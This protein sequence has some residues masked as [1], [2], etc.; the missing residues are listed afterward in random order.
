MSKP[1]QLSLSRVSRRPRVT[2][3]ATTGVANK[4]PTRFSFRST[5]KQQKSSNEKEQQIYD[6]LSLDSGFV[7]NLEN[8]I[9]IIFAPHSI[10]GG[11]QCGN[12]DDLD[13]TSMLHESQA[14][15]IESYTDCSESEADYTGP[16]STY[17]FY[18]SNGNDNEEDWRETKCNYISL[19]FRSM[20]LTIFPEQRL[21]SC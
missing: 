5:K 21:F 10:Q 15:A 6:D 20:Q 14:S 1:L 9:E 12:D 4:M 13:R 18:Q 3:A 2:A 7:R 17:S 16:G 19:F 11:S 8:H